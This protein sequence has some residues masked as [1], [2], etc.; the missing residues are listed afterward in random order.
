M[1]EAL[2][3][4]C[5]GLLL[6]MLMMSVR[7]KTPAKMV[8]PAPTDDPNSSRYPCT[9]QESSVLHYCVE[10]AFRYTPDAFRNPHMPVDNAC[11][12]AVPCHKGTRHPGAFAVRCGAF[13]ILGTRLLAVT[14]WHWRGDSLTLV[15]IA[16]H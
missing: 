9:N 4:L 5:L 11:V 14:A 16:W 13:L 12:L 7:M 15:L 3:L 8:P 6:E 10:T 2:E 1:L